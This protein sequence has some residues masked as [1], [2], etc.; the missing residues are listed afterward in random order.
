MFPL[1]LSD[2][3]ARF[4]SLSQL[5]EQQQQQQRGAFREM[6]PTLGTQPPSLLP[7]S[8]PIKKE[9]LSC[10]QPKVPQ[11][12]ATTFTRTPTGPRCQPGASSS[13]SIRCPCHAYRPESWDGR[14]CMAAEMLRGGGREGAVHTHT[15]THTASASREELPGGDTEDG[16][17]GSMCVCREH[18]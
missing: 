12:P 15:H 4:S 11:Q 14:L 16:A 1:S 10:A 6:I 2:L 18:T 7:L 13:P 9:R 8:R 17:G 5:V 3:S